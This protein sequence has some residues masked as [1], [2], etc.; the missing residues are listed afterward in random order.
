MD[1]NLYLVIKSISKSGLVLEPIDTI[2][3]E[4]LFVVCL[5][6]VCGLGC[7]GTFIK[8]RT[9]DFGLLWNFCL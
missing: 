4:R 3:V 9:L 2:L 8:I 7:F 6:F 1:S 5:V